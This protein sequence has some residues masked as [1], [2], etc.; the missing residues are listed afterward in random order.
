MR[1]IRPGM[2]GDDVE[3]WQ[4]FLRGKGYLVRATGGSHDAESV[5]ASQAWQKD[6]GLVDD[7]VLGP[8]TFGIAQGEGF[9]PGFIDEDASEVGPNWPAKPVFAP[10]DSEA[11]KRTFGSSSFDPQPIRAT[12][13]R[14]RSSMT[15]RTRTSSRSTSRS[16]SASMA[17]RSRARFGYTS[18]R[19]IR[20]GASSA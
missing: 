17:R 11:R 19:S 15:G 5:K 10:L 1:V 2:Q 14:S 20:F 16:S 18:S 6:H 13:K 9:N 8:R 12:P 7:G 3:R 4:L